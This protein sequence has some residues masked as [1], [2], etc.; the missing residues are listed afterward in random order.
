MAYLYSQRQWAP[1]GSWLDCALLIRVP[2]YARLHTHTRAHTRTGVP[3]DLRE[4]VW[5]ALASRWPDMVT[6]DTYVDLLTEP[7]IYHHAIKIDIG[8]Q[9]KHYTLTKELRTR[10]EQK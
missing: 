4:A 6:V 2:C 7:C 10:L 3:D 1:V 5:T 8:A 9:R